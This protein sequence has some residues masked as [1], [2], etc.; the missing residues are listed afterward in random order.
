MSILSREMGMGSVQ[1]KSRFIALS[2]SSLLVGSRESNLSIT[3]QAKASY[4]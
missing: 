1:K 4:T 3:S 2:A